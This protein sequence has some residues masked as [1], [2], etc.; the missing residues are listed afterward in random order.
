MAEL[1][2]IIDRFHIPGGETVYT[3]RPGK[4]AVLR[5]EDI[6]LDLNVSAQN[7]PKI[8]HKMKGE[9]KNEI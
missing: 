2:R 5:L 4:G 6:L 7:S 8:I 3:V 9:I 1:F